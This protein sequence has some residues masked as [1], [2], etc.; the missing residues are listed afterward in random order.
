VPTDIY[1]KIYNVVRLIPPGKVATYGQ[2]A[3]LTGMTGQA[4]LVGYALHCLPKNSDIP[5]H[6]VVNRL[7]QISLSQSLNDSGAVQR[8]LLESEG[9]YFNLDGSVELQRYQWYE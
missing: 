7:G 9:I 5:W 4:R 1:S 6:R 8:N 2:I 3:R